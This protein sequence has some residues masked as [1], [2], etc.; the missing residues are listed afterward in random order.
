MLSAAAYAIR[1]TVHGVTRFTPSQ[2]VYQKDMMFRTQ[3]EADT[4]LIRQRRKAAAIVNNNRENRR[5]I[6]H[7][8]KAGDRIL[9]LATGMDPKMELHKG[10]YKVVSY[11][12]N[13]GTLRIKRNNYIEPINVRNVRP[14]F[15]E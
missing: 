3:V 14:Y 1:A 10:P 9:I 15:K 2:L 6:S 5:R 13:S 7:N 4:E 11:D 12:K 8:Y